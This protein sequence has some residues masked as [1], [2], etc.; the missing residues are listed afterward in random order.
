MDYINDLQAILEKTCILFKNFQFSASQKEPGVDHFI[1]YRQYDS[2]PHVSEI[3]EG[4]GLVSFRNFSVGVDVQ[5]AVRLNSKL[6][7]AINA[8]LGKDILVDGTTLLNVAVHYGCFE[9]A[10]LLVALGEYLALWDVVRPGDP[11][12]LVCD[13]LAKQ[14]ESEGLIIIKNYNR[15]GG[16]HI[17][18]IGDYWHES[19]IKCYACDDSRTKH[20]SN[21]NSLTG[22]VKGKEDYQKIESLFVKGSIVS[23]GLLGDAVSQRVLI[24]GCP[25][26]RKNLEKLESLIIANDGWVTLDIVE[27]SKTKK[28]Y[29]A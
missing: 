12:F 27:E 15:A 18:S 22:I 25:Q 1:S 28:C 5:E 20:V 19:P 14:F 29:T 2:L 11:S 8:T 3:P 9:V 10:I 13:R 16:V 6:M 26:H 23:L 17:E 4:F 21:I 7:T 24:G